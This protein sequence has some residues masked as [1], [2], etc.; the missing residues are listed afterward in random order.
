MLVVSVLKLDINSKTVLCFKTTI[1]K[2]KVMIV[3]LKDF[4]LVVTNVFIKYSSVCR[5]E[6][7]SISVCLSLS[8]KP[9]AEYPQELNYLF[10]FPWLKS[11]TNVQLSLAKLE[12]H[13][14]ALFLCTY[15]A[16]N[17]HSVNNISLTLK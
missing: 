14:S 16:N 2:T 7:A 13:L 15:K 8:K 9:Q 12:L 1:L 3:F 5:G 11:R 6:M 10:K 4:H 17:C